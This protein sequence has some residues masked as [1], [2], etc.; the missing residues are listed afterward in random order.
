MNLD[1]LGELDKFFGT[2]LSKFK[3]GA[4]RS[5]VQTADFCSCATSSFVSFF[6]VD[7]F[8][9]QHSAILCGAVEKNVEEV[10]V[11]SRNTFHSIH[12]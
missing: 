4:L 7:Q 1:E 12:L 2:N 11:K 5:A 8:F 10:K 6:P 9:Y 3:F